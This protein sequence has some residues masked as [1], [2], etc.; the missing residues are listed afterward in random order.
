MS[1]DTEVCSLCS[2]SEG[3]DWVQHQP[4]E[5]QATLATLGINGPLSAEQRDEVEREFVNL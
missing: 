3:H 1:I 5:Y 4:V 2:R